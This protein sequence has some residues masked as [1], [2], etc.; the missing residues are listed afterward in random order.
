MPCSGWLW[1]LHPGLARA[2]LYSGSGSSFSAHKL[3]PDIV[4]SPSE[5]S[6]EKVIG[7]HIHEGRVGHGFVRQPDS[8][9]KEYG[10]GEPHTKH[11]TKSAV[12]GKLFSG[13]VRHGHVSYNDIIGVWRFFKCS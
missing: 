5:L 12:P 6:E 8:N 4:N 10:R 2:F 1:H 9:G 3:Y 13:H 11:G 7:F